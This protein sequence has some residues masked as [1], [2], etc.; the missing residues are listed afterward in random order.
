MLRKIVC[1]LLLGSVISL[2]STQ[3]GA[4][5]LEKK[6]DKKLELNETSADLSHEEG[7]EWRFI[8]SL[9]WRKFSPLGAQI[10]DWND[11]KKVRGWRNW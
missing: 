5:D 3:V 4:Q 7:F 9:G 8:P 11:W 1:L 10:K 6:N 2:W